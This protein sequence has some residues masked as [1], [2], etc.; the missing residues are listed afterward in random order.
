MA[1]PIPIP[2]PVATDLQTCLADQQAVAEAATADQAAQ[3]ALQQ[4]TAAQQG[5][6]HTLDQARA[7]LSADYAA[8][9]KDLAQLFGQQPAA[10]QP[11]AAPQ[12]R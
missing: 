9:Q 2:D 7:K 12:R 11:A 3:A 10:P 4:A 8:L 5:T 1:D 6:A